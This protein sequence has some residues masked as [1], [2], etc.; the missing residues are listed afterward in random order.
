MGSTQTDATG[1]CVVAR[2]WDQ[3][4][5]ICQAIAPEHLEL[6]LAEPQ[7]LET[8]LKSNLVIFYGRVK[9]LLSRFLRVQLA[10]R[11]SRSFALPISKQFLGTA[12]DSL[13]AYSSAVE[14]PK[15]SAITEPDRTTYCPPLAQRGLLPTY[16]WKLFCVVK[17]GC[18]S[19]I[20]PRRSP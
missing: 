5:E 7:F 13:P 17:R 2:D 20:R 14:M 6:H 18:G 1:F 19:T 8:V 11:L 9:L 4:L 10:F 3:A 15:C 12:F 16:R